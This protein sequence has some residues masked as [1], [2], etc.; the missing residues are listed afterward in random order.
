MF[1]SLTDLVAN[2]GVVDLTIDRNDEARHEFRR[3]N[4]ISYVPFAA[5][6]QIMS[7]N[8]EGY[9]VRR[10]RVTLL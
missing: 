6:Y 1:V 8:G 2:Q 10:V 4:D 3:Y 7:H 9:V 5:D